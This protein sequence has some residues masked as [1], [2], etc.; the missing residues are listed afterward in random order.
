MLEKSQ[1]Y[2]TF[3]RKQT[4]TMPSGKVSVVFAFGYSS[5]SSE[6]AEPT[7]MKP[8]ILISSLL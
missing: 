1:A 4:E 5:S 7:E 3:L 2:F 6:A 8:P